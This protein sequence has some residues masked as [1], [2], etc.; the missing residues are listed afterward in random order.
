VVLVADGVA[1]ADLVGVAVGVA[2]VEVVG[3]ADA[4]ACA[5][6]LL[7]A[8]GVAFFV[9]TGVAFLVATGFVVADLV[10]DAVGVAETVELSV[11]AG[12]PIAP[13]PD[14]PREFV[15]DNCGGVIAITAPSPPKV[16]P[17]INSA[18]FIFLA[19]RS[20]HPSCLPYQPC[21]S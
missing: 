5:V 6:A 11:I 15:D 20:S 8:A 12:A 9:V 13:A 16:P 7:L 21:F 2:E 1:V 17:A 10:D 14:M 19:S 18:L 3:V 4:L